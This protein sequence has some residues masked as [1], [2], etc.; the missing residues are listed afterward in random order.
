[1]ADHNTRKSAIER[2]DEAILHLTQGQTALT[3]NHLELSRKVDTILDRL[4]HLENNPAS[5]PKTPFHS[6]PPLKLEVPRFDG[7]DPMGWIFKISQFFDY[8]G[9]PEDERITVASFIWTA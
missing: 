3:N 2:L 1:M 8:Q 6:R 4:A 5:P 9:T 7:H